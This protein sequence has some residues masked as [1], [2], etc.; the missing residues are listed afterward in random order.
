MNLNFRNRDLL[1]LKIL[2]WRFCP[3]IQLQLRKITITKNVQRA[4]TSLDLRFNAAAERKI[5]QEQI[6]FLF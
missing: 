6:V 4:T 2:N 1:I 5:Y 3:A